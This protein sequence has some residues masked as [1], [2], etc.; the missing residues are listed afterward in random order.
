MD[1]HLD[2]Y[3]KADELNVT[4]AGGGSRG[5]GAAGGWLQ[6]GGHGP[7]GGLHGMGVD[8]KFQLDAFQCWYPPTLLLDVL[9]FTMVTADGNI[10]YANAC[11]NKDLF[12]ALR[13][14]GSGTWG[15]SRYVIKFLTNY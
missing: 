12:W 11:Q 15:V 4:V 8:S 6:G 14:G 10:V 9:Q 3:K 7:L 1:K 5:V 13:G 2:V